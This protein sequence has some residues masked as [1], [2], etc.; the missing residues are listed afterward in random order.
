MLPSA[1][2]AQR[3]Q[4][5]LAVFAHPDDERIIGPLLSRLVRVFLRVCVVST[6]IEL[7]RYR[8]MWSIPHPEAAGARAPDEAI[9]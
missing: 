9:L 7:R 8:S 6:G 4:P 3:N 2:E 1:A 5:V